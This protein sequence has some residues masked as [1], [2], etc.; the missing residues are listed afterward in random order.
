MP[1]ALRPPWQQGAVCEHRTGEDDVEKGLKSDVN[2][3]T[4]MSFLL[5]THVF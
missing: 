4:K 1:V 5:V 3:V 2:G